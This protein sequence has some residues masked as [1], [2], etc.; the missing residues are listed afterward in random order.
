MI[1]QQKQ[2]VILMTLTICKENRTVLEEFINV[3][4]QIRIAEASLN[5]WKKRQKDLQDSVISQI[6]ETGENNIKVGQ[7]TIYLHK[8]T[9]CSIDNADPLALQA[10]EV[11][12][13]GSLIKHQVNAMD[14]TAHFKKEWGEN[15]GAAP[16]NLFN[17][18]KV[19]EEVSARSRE[20]N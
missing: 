12:G 7:T 8:K 18:L 3:Q 10:I 17:F 16:A 1:W 5:F 13:L 6:V 20:N 11:A 14:L 19:T 9:W 4:K 15:I 2:W